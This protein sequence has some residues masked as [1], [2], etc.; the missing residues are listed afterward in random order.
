MQYTHAAAASATV[1]RVLCDPLINLVRN[2]WAPRR[3]LDKSCNRGLALRDTLEGNE[4]SRKLTQI[5]LM[6]LV[7]VVL[8]LREMMK[9]LAQSRHAANAVQPVLARP[10]DVG[11][12]RDRT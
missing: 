2:Q 7:P 4:N 9:P 10:F 8:L 3:Q 12:V 5:L 6:P 11:P 1:S